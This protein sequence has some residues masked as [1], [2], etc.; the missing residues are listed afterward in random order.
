MTTNQ[1]AN[2]SRQWHTICLTIVTISTATIGATII[3]A[4]LPE[5]SPDNGAPSLTKAALAF[6]AASAHIALAGMTALVIF[7]GDDQANEHAQR[8]RALIV[9]MLFI[10]IIVLLTG[11][12]T[13]NVLADLVIPLTGPEAAAHHN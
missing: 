8:N 10:T 12:L 13:T 11:V 1:Q 3:L 4:G 7:A 2:A 9:Y 6:L 5:L